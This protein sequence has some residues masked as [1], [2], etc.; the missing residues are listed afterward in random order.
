MGAPPRAQ[1]AAAGLG[2]P[3]SVSP[4]LFPGGQ[5]GGLA[6]WLTP[7]STAQLGRGQV[8]L[9]VLLEAGTVRRGSEQH[10]YDW[11]FPSSPGTA[12]QAYPITHLHRRKPR[13][14]DTEGSNVPE[15][16]NSKLDNWVQT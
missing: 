4:P 13:L 11:G 5:A 16:T 12:Y 14:R 10:E 3:V 2:L 6:N 7:P 9:G 8:G 1:G 15:V